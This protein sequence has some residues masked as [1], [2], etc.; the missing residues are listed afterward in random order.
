MGRRVARG[1]K[2]GEGLSVPRYVLIGDG[3]SPHLLKWAREL[4]RRVE[5]YALSSRGFLPDFEVIVPAA[6]RLSLRRSLDAS[7]GNFALLKA[8]LPVARWLKSIQPDVV[9]AHYLTSHGTLA[10]LARMLFRSPGILVGSAWGSDVLIAPERSTVLRWLTQRVLR[11]CDLT[12]SDSHHM[13]EKMRQYGA[14][15]VMVFPFGLEALPPEPSDKQGHLFFANRGLESGYDPARVI[16]LFAGVIKHWPD[17]RLV[18]ARDGPLLQFLREKVHALNLDDRVRF[19]GFLDSQTQASY[20]SCARWYLSLP[21][22]DSVSVSVLESMAYG[23]IPILSDLPANREL[24]ESMR[25]GLILPPGRLPLA[26]DLECL[27]SKADEVSSTNRSW[28][29]DHALFGPSVDLFFSRVDALSQ[30]R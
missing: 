12:T 14:R 5:L 22:S 27:L 30:S 6:R 16:E 18:I 29:R 17:A 19:T 15:E 4:S 23:C 11:A 21:T 26:S 20:Y 8:V 9:H 13:A 7:G 25:N 3:E 1:A 10:W 24:V 2:E 28:V